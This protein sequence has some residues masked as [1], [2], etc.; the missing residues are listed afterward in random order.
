VS[1]NLPAKAHASLGASTS[2]RWMACPGSIR[3]SDGIPNIETPY[4]KEGTVAHAV[5]ERCLTNRA[6]PHTLVGVNWDGVEV[7][8]DMTEFV[9]IFV[10]YCRKLMETATKHWIEYRFSLARLNPPEAMFGTSDFDAYDAAARRLT[11]VDLKYGQGV[12]VEAKENEQLRYYALGVALDLGAQGFEI[13]EVEMVIVQ[14]RAP[15][16]DGIVRSET[17]SVLELVEW[18][19]V[20][21]D[22]A[23]ATQDPNAPLVAG[24]HCRFCPAAAVCPERLRHAQALA[25]LEFSAMPAEPPRPET[26]P[27]EVLARIAPNLGAIED[28][29]ASIR[30]Y[31]LSECEKGRGDDLGVKLVAKRATRKWIDEEAVRQEVKSRGFDEE[32]IESRKL[33]SPAQLEKV[34]GKKN[35]EAW[36]SP[37]VKKESSGV[38]VVSLDDP[39][40][41]VQ[42]APVFSVLPPAVE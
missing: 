12:V 3:M 19:G 38:N 13:E 32:E 15:H 18:A 36:L 8:E 31:L 28:Y 11:V 7:T 35:A 25:Q 22:A 21:L 29:I 30:A 5:A 6:D 27:R 34:V 14:P 42:T 10:D 37:H 4:A 40:E 20:L 24:S 16:P 41:A 2:H 23:R 33:K 17:I 9:G 39:R 1:S 26:L